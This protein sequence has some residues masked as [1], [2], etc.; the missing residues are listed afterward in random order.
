MLARNAVAPG[1][2]KLEVTESLVM[3]NP[4]YAA[5]VLGRMRE[6]GAGLCLDDFGTCY[7]SLAYLQRFPFDSV[8]IDPR[9][10][11]SVAK[12]PSRAARPVIVGAMID[13]AH[14]LGMDVM[15]EGLEKETEAA[16]M[17]RF[18][19]EYG[20]GVVFGEPLTAEECRHLIEPAPAETRKKKTS[21][22]A[23]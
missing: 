4:E 11:R 6:L 10:V 12:G 15:A 17:T 8:K 23:E 13:L 2:L 5:V 18:G 3:E 20:Q 19:C 21:T 1:S 7:S 14:D 16:E 22:A 9:F